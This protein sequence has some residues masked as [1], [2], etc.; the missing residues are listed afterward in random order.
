MPSC[1]YHWDL[2]WPAAHAL[3]QILIRMLIFTMSTAKLTKRNT[4][5]EPRK[6]RLVSLFS[7]CGG[8]DLGFHQAGYDIVWANNIDPDACENYRENIGDIIEG[9]VTNLPIPELKD[10]DVLT[11]GFPCQALA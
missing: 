4:M 10:I 3:L 2:C 7:G 1:P 11:S 5:T 6:P 9:D 8:M